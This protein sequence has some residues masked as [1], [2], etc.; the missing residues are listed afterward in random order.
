M[1]WKENG[2]KLKQF[3]DILQH[4]NPSIAFTMEKNSHKLPFLDILVIK[5]QNKIST[6]IYHKPTDTFNYVSFLSSHPRHTKAAI[7]YNLARR[8]CTIVTNKRQKNIRLNKLRQKLLV[9]GYPLSL[10]N[11]GI[12]KASLIPV[13]ELRNPP[14][15]DKNIETVVPIVTTHNPNNSNIFPQ[16]RT[17]FNLLKG[18]RMKKVQK[19]TNLINSKRQPPNLKKILTNANFTE[20]KIKRGTTQCKSVKCGTCKYMLE[21]QQIVFNNQPQS[22]YIIKSPLNCLAKN[23]IYVINCLSCSKQYIGQTSSLRERVTVHRQQIREPQLRKLPISKH[24]AYCT[25]PDN[26]RF[27]ICPI[28]QKNDKTQ[29]EILESNLITKYKPELNNI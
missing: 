9:R 26:P 27:T 16:I 25:S 10:I 11:S 3:N 28:L 5:D 24:L 15:Q 22:P 1:I 17:R 6:D 19:E 18:N 2:E 23:V 7:P 4:L 8:I 20:N 13:E 12:K 21:T 29:R 14:K